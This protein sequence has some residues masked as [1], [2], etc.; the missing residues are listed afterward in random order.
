MLQALTALM[1]AGI[2]FGIALRRP[3]TA[4][5]VLLAL[6]PFHGLL[7]IAPVTGT[8]WKE[9]SVLAIVTASF[10]TPQ[11]DEGY[12]AH[13]Q[14]AAPLAILV[15][16]GIVSALVA[17]GTGAFFP[18]KI[19]FF[20]LL[21]LLVIARFPFTARDKHRLITVILLTGTLTAAYGIAQQVLQGEALVDMGYK[22]GEQVRTTGPLLRSFGT[23]NQPFPFGLYLMVALITGLSASV[24][25]PGRT[26][27][28]AFWPAATLML[29]A[30][31]LS[32]VRASYIGLLVGLFVLGATQHP[33]IMKA[34]QATIAVGAAGILTLLAL[35]SG[36]GKLGA[37]FSSSSLMQRLSHWTDSFK[38]V[39]VNPLGTGL[40][41][42]G[43]SAEKAGP[44]VDPLHPP[45]QPDNQ[46]LK[47]MLELGFVGMALYIAIVALMVCALLQLL[48]QLPTRSV[49]YAFVCI[50]LAAT[51]AACVAG[52]FATYLEIFPLEI[53]FWVL[54][55]IACCAP[56][57]A[58]LTDS[59]ATTAAPATAAR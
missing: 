13:L 16:F 34:L 57:N 33:K 7:A 6:V 40:G 25:E 42:T 28:R 27:S 38:L 47:I 4:V 2:I 53:L 19:A 24:L 46:Y 5:V 11:R 54:P 18:I 50:A 26:R 37:L 31:V 30:L 45:Y 55:A 15:P 20:Y 51:A 21:L 35:F 43:S 32:V 8:Y 3:Q 14:W 12:R 22:W 58:H 52:V 23:F 36:N 39:L 1:L 56:V 17:H 41:N 29:P 49:D 59:P 44:G 48:R 9:L 10:I